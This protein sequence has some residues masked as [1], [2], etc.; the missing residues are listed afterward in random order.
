M[1]VGKYD[2]SRAVLQCPHRHFPGI[3][4]RTVQGAEKQVIAAQHPV[5]TV[6][7]DAAEYLPLSMAQVILEEATG[8]GW[9][10]QHIP[11]GNDLQG[12]P[13]GKFQGS[14]Q[15]RIPGQAQPGYGQ[16]LAAVGTHHAR[17]ATEFV[18]QQTG[19][20]QGATATVT[21][22]QQQGQKF[23]IG[24]RRLSPFQ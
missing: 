6:Q 4:R 20:V 14:T 3:H 10:G 7:E 5:L 23:S 12:L 21:G 13:A 17:Q 22:M 18:E 15:L 9:A 11:A 1:I 2:G 19:K 8:V 16:Q 24:Q